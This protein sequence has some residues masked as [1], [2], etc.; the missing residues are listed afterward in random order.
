N[1]VGVVAGE[2]A[3]DDLQHARVDREHQAR[4]GGLQ[5]LADEPGE[6]L[7]I[8]DAGD[9]SDLAFQTDGDHARPRLLAARQQGDMAT[10]VRSSKSGK[11]GQEDRGAGNAERGTRSETHE[12][13]LRAP[14]S[15]LR[16]RFYC[17][18]RTSAASTAWR[19]RGSLSLRNWA[20]ACTT[21]LLLA[22]I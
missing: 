11:S 20:S 19:T 7:V 14:S 18:S 12:V 22:C 3:L 5:R 15:A 4:P 17:R 1:V 13:S 21:L 2:E 10:P 16:V 9:Q 8:A 6:A